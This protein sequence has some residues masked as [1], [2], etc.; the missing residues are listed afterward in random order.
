MA[1]KTKL[2]EQKP[3]T[4]RIAAPTSKR[5]PLTL[6]EERILADYIRNSGRMP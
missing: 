5:K 2:A 6:E 1:K 3:A 4:K